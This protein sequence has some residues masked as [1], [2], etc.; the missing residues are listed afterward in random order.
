MYVYINIFDN[1]LKKYARF[2]DLRYRTYLSIV[3]VFEIP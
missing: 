3:I 1:N 2:T